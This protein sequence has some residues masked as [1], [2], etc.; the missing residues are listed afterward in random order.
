MN[1]IDILTNSVKAKT[2]RSK[3]IKNKKTKR[4]HTKS[5]QQFYW[6]IHFYKY[7]KSDD[8]ARLLFCIKRKDTKFNWRSFFSQFD[9]FSPNILLLSLQHWS[10][11]F[12]FCTKRRFIAATEI[13]TV[14]SS[15]QWVSCIQLISASF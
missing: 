6:K 15:P 10:Y 14:Y 12:F 9:V 11:F 2:K 13:T 3:A 7:P 8:D 1:K 5:K 4:R